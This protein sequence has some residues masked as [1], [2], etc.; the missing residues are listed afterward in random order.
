MPCD[1]HAILE[2]I[3]DIEATAWERFVSTLASVRV[4]EDAATVTRG[5]EHARRA[6]EA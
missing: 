4:A 1:E 6:D 5:D 3:P 2:R